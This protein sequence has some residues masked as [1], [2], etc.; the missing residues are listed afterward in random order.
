MKTQ[1]Q[2]KGVS[3]VAKPHP[4]SQRQIK[5]VVSG[6]KTVAE[7]V[8]LVAPHKSY[9][10]YARVCVGPSLVPSDMWHCVRVKEG[11]IVSIVFVPRRGGGKNPLSTVLSIALLVAAPGI[12]AS[13][14][15]ATGGWV[16]STFFGVSFLGRVFGA[17]VG[18]VGSLVVNAL[19]PP[20]KPPAAAAT[21][22]EGTT[23]FISGAQ[24]QANLYGAIPAVLGK[25]R[26]VPSIGM[27]PFTEQ[28]G[29]NQYVRQLFVW[30]HGPLDI[31]D[32]RIGDTP[33]EE[34]QDVE[35]ETRQGFDDDEPLTLI[36]NDP[37]EVQL[38]VTLRSGVYNTQTTAA[39][40]DQISFDVTFTRGLVK[41]AAS[42]A[43]RAMTVDIDYEYSPTGAGT[44]TAATFTVTKVQSA[45]FRQ[46]VTIP[47]TRGQY[48]VRL[49]RVTA[50]SVDTSTFDEVVW[51]S[52]RSINNDPPVI[53]K[54]AMTA[55]RIRA[56]DQLNGVISQ[57][58]GVVQSIVPDFDGAEWDDPEDQS[59]WHATSNPASLFRHV[60]QGAANK[61]PIA[62]SRIDLTALEDWHTTCAENGY[63]YNNVI[64]AQRSVK[65][66][67]DAIAACGRAKPGRPD[68]KWLVV[69]DKEK[70]V[71]VQHFTP[72][73]SWGFMGQRTYVDQPHAFRVKFINRETNW[74]EDAR[75]VFDDG[76]SENGEVPGTVAATEYE[77]IDLTDGVTSADQAWKDGRYHIASARLRPE[78]YSFYAD[79]ENLVCTRG[80]L[81]RVTHDV[82]LFGLSCARLKNV[83]LDGNSPANVTG[84]I[85]DDPVTME[86]DK[87]YNVRLRLSDGDSLLKSIE[88]VM[89]EQ[90]E[91][92]FSTPFPLGSLA[93]AEGNIVM[94]GETG[95]ES[96]ELV[97]KDITRQSELVAKVICV[98]Y[99]PALFSADTGTIPDHDSQI[100][101]PP[102]LRRPPAPVIVSVQSGDDA[103]IY[104]ADG[105][106]S[107]SIMVT[108]APADF[109][110]PLTPV[111][112]IRRSD[113]TGYSPA[114][115][116][117]NSGK[118]IVTDVQTGSYYSLK[119][120][121]KNPVGLYSAATERTGILVDADTSIGD[122]DNLN[123]NV[124]G[125][126]AHL[127]WDAVDSPRLA[128]YTIRFSPQ[129]S[130]VTWS[131]AADLV[132]RVPKN[133]T[134]VSV[135]AA[136]G[137]F[138]I[139]AIDLNGNASANADIVTSTIAGLEGY[140]A[141]E[142]VT[143]DTD[144]TGDKTSVVVS[145]G[146]L[147]LGPSDSI[148][149][150]DDIDD[151]TSF[152]MGEAGLSTSGTYDFAGS[153][154]LGAV[155]TSRV[156]LDMDVIGVDLNNTVDLWSNV[157]LQEDWDQDADPSTWNVQIQIRTTED[158]PSGSPVSWSGWM[159]F[160]IGDYTARA[161]EF[162][163]LLTST[164]AGIT[165]S[166][167]RLRVN[168]DMPDRTDAQR[169]ISSNAAGST[170]SFVTPFKATPAI[171]VTAQ[172]M[173]TG[174][175][176]AI[177]TPTETGF[178]IR[179]FNAAGT[180]IVRTFDY[181]AKGY[182]LQS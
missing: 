57:L 175:Y 39:N 35:I 164:A 50:D 12:G 95:Q 131:S 94:F 112:L 160:V 38:S 122:V 36:T 29:D 162:R 101:I 15:A 26:M 156:T 30:G 147:Q 106:F 51:T 79:F 47:V 121:N 68:G 37:R 8:A 108:L 46:N 48:D 119:I 71:P 13:L 2:N 73:N 179:F 181:L 32:I 25:K 92:Q 99:A 70:T 75:N 180:G 136:V 137:T 64:D 98:D 111:V 154:D 134:S 58:S 11:N 78:S 77:S 60:L 88:T 4:L 20:P 132:S 146:A 59:T 19:A 157:D 129:T 28:S 151:V 153:V 182:G 65:D 133:S 6:G 161:F 49:K 72:R 61:R 24:N 141:I 18:L 41:F 81:V 128:Y 96:V 90:S 97:V 126:T 23:H 3:V 117:E 87:T 130:G 85:V 174:D 34:F 104:N 1:M 167:S 66:M 45:A 172:D 53:G 42:G 163:A 100:S 44:W 67:L 103:L 176:Y 76:Y 115:F 74:L 54:W 52:L 82:P 116:T 31:S 144:F 135:P 149:D 33:I 86:S 56:T 125:P 109:P 143:E 120:I 10:P 158:D 118:I 40:T 17:A 173:A 84:I 148:D 93:L 9:E 63:E 138:L 21:R 169:N 171:A 113:E 83:I 110:I 102:D 114:S 127:T 140:N 168:V 62:D 150:W 145:S 165:P 159:P 105:S 155:Y 178:D 5:K 107:P 22:S 89:G 152:D 123:M 170:I 69:E 177:T 27:R 7:L 166:I 91:L 80:D 124:L 14:A 139:K 55:V 16:G 142:T 43:K